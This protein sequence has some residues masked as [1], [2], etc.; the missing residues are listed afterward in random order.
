MARTARGVKTFDVDIAQEFKNLYAQNDVLK[1]EM[2]AQNI[3]LRKEIQSLKES[4]NDWKSSFDKQLD[5]LNDNMSKVLNQIADH[6]LRLSELERQ[7]LI[8]STK[9]E[10][11]SELAKFGWYAGKVVLTVGMVIGSALGGAKV[12]QMMFQ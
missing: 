2:N 4:I 12:W 10:T 1:Q 7:R 8:N 9:V 6:E 3:E 5:K 11:V